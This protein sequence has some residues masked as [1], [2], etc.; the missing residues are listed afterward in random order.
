MIYFLTEGLGVSQL[1][2]SDESYH[3]LIKVRR[4]RVGDQIALR[5]RRDLD[6]LY[7]Y[8][9]THITRKDL[10]LTLIEHR[11][12]PH[13]STSS[14][15]IGW[16]LID[17]KIIEKS[18]PTLVEQGMRHISFFPAERSQ[19]H[20]RLDHERLDRI[21]EGAMM[22]CGR[23][24]RM[25]IE[26]YPSLEAFVQSYPEA[27]LLD[28]GGE[29]LHYPLPQTII[30]GPE[31]GFTAQERAMVSHH[32]SFVHGHVLRSESAVISLAALAMIG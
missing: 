22:Q 29:A 9:I 10:H 20:F 13:T 11:H 31:G 3:Y 26:M 15:H 30:V 12:A 23:S 27:V 2:M 25:G 18:L 21:I 6:T 32:Y 17:P 28:F 1:T 14:L 7:T 19:R 8:E 4:H 5:D 24:D 16:S